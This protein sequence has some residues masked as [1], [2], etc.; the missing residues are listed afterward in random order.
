MPSYVADA[1]ELDFHSRTHRHLPAPEPLVPLGQLRALIAHLIAAPVPGGPDI[2][3]LVEVLARG[4]LPRVLPKE[5]RKGMARKIHVLLDSAGSMR[6]FQRDA[7][8]LV[9][10]LRDVAGP[11]IMSEK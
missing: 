1:E 5:K 7:T 6:L 4:R 2:P 3:Q 10:A 8:E 9:R 11:A